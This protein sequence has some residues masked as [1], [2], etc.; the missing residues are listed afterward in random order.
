MKNYQCW[1]GKSM[2]T[3]GGKWTVAWKCSSN[4]S[5]SGNWQVST[6]KKLEC[7]FLLKIFSPATLHKTIWILLRHNLGCQSGYQPLYPLLSTS[8]FLVDKFNLQ[9]LLR[10]VWLNQGSWIRQ[11]SKY[12]FATFS[13]Y[14]LQQF[15]LRW[16]W[17]LSSWLFKVKW[18]FA[19]IQNASKFCVA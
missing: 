13:C 16:C 10:S 3:V 18:Q 7:Q 6:T 14:F 15:N 4:P 17:N 8:W 1:W 11:V 19:T 2:A 5:S 12:V 9:C